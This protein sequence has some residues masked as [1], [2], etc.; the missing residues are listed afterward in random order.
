M[1]LVSLYGC[2]ALGTYSPL[3]STEMLQDASLAETMA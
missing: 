2:A 3:A 1:K